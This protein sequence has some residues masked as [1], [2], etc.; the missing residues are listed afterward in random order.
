MEIVLNVFLPLV[1]QLLVLYGVSQAI[2]RL[3][4]RY[5]G[6]GWYLALT[7]PGVVVHELSHFVGCII[8][9]TRVTRVELFHPHG[10][11][12][13]MVEHVQTRNP[14][15]NIIISIA[16]LFGVTFIMWLLTRWAMPT[17]YHDQLGVVR[18]ALQDADT[19]SHFFSLSGAFI[20]QYWD[21]LTELLSVIDFGQWQ[22]YLFL[23]LMI[24]LSSHA[25]PSNVDLKHT[26]FG[27]AGLGILFFLLILIDRWLQTQATWIV[28]Q[29]LS[30]PVYF[31]AQFLTIG[32]FFSFVSLLVMG[33]LSMMGKFMKKGSI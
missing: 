13:G 15:K 11:T 29:W 9:F 23:Y 25:A 12:L 10:N 3:V 20:S 31:L 6:R 30:G 26:Y 8:T 1:L 32:I 24:T 14:I 5:L 22:T 33:G 21:S 17:F 16:P 7:W 4:L 19:Y 18:G 28:V 2:D 27:V